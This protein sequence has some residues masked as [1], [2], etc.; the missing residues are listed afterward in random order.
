M[1]AFVFRVTC[2]THSAVV[3]SRPRATPSPLR[4]APMPLT[5]LAPWRVSLLRRSPHPP[6][7]TS[8]S[9]PPIRYSI[10][11]LGL[12]DV[13]RRSD[14]F[15][16][17]LGD[18]AHLDDDRAVVDLEAVDVVGR[19]ASADLV[20]ALHHQCAVA[21]VRQTGGSEQAARSGSDDD[22]VELRVDSYVVPFHFG[23]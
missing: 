10:G 17:L 12:P 20:E 9:L 5:S 11:G 1:H 22:D 6:P 23:I 7:V 16:G 4:A 21:A 13:E 15:T 19:R 8:T 2:D 14:L 3:R 18:A